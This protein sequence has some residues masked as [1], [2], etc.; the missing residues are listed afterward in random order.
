MSLHDFEEN[1]CILTTQRHCPCI[2]FH[3]TGEE[4]HGFQV[5]QLLHYRLES[6]ENVSGQP[7]H[8]LTL[9]FG[10]A[11]VILT[12]WRLDRVADRVRDGNLLAVRT[13]T[14]RYAGL[15]RTTP[16]VASII[17]TPITKE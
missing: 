8:K 12:G 9:G 13:C 5:S 3:P 17:V 1:E 6:S 14:V 10:T 7:P 11:D 2:E 16:H 15:S 4:R